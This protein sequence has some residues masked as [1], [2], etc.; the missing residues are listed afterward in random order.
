M[1]PKKIDSTARKGFLSSSLESG[2]GF[3][4]YARDNTECS[5]KDF[6]QGYVGKHH[7]LV[8]IYSQ[9]VIKLNPLLKT[10]KTAVYAN[11]ILAIETY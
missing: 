4:V 5:R 2:K 3:A 7:I 6:E 9:S 11:S 8:V 10:L 1:H